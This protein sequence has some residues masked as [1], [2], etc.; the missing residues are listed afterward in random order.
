MEVGR[1]YKHGKHKAC[2]TAV[3]SRVSVE[4]LFEKITMLRPEDEPLPISAR[5]K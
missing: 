5:F 3:D 2:E 4:V 1:V